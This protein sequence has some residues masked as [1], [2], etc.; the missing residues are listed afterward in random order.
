MA[1][2]IPHKPKSKLEEFICDADLDYMGTPK[3][4]EIS[5]TLYKEWLNYGMIENRV[6]WLER[7]IGF[8][9][10]HTYYSAFSM[11]LRQSAKMKLLRSLEQ[12]L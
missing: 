11:K 10:L 1:T 5:E 8:L 9:K 3:Y 2:K 6:Q 4:E 12:N 7:Q